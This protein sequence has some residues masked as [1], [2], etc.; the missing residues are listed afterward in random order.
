MLIFVSNSSY[1][2]WFEVKKNEV[3]ITVQE[4]LV[5]DQTDNWIKNVSAIKTTDLDVYRI[6]PPMWTKHQ[7]GSAYIL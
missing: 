1:V 3:H 4:A 2:L 7:H 5:T 6:A